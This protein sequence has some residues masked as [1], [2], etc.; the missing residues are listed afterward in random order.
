[1]SD[2]TPLE[3]LDEAV[4]EFSAAC[5]NE[6]IVAGWVIAYQLTAITQEEGVSPLL[7][8]PDYTMSPSTTGELATGLLRLISKRIEGEIIA[9]T[10]DDD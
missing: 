10:A 6:G 7:S 8:R 3:R 1:M 4:R 2:P 5:D 9:T